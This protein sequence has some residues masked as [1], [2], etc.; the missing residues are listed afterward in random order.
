[1]SRATPHASIAA[2][3]ERISPL[4][5]AH[6]DRVFRRILPG[7]DT[8]VDRHFIRIQTGEPHPF[9]NFACVNDATNAACARQ[10][11]EPLARQN[12][13]AATIFVGSPS[14]AVVQQLKE[15]GFERHGEMVMMAVDIEP[16]SP[17][18]L[19]AGYTF[20]RVSAMAD[21]DRWADAF[22]RGYELPPQAGASFARALDGNA[23]DDADVR[24]FWIRHG[25]EPVCTSVLFLHDGVAGVYGVATI[26][27]ARKKGLGAHAT[28]EPLRIARKLGYRVGVLQASK[29][30]HPVYRRIGFSDFGEIPL[31]VRLPAPA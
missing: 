18:T 17:T 29:L 31:F 12:K 6:L 11:I 4:I 7:A 30:G 14:D 13:P 16:L 27:D 10:A 19:P 8:T 25:D 9:A 23:A 21:R 5:N 26:P 22:T 20:A 24:Y 3:G 1:M 15:F 28:A 2:I